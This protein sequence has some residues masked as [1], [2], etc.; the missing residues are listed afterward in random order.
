MLGSPSDDNCTSHFTPNQV[1]R[2]HCY[3]DLVYQNWMTERHPAS[4]PLAP[5]VT[6]HTQGSVSIHWLP[7][8]RG[9]LYQRYKPTVAEASPPDP[10]DMST[11]SPEVGIMEVSEVLML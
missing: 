8:I 9:P 5:V 2:M 11:F 6:D 1:A 10:G 3:L 7:P 4:I